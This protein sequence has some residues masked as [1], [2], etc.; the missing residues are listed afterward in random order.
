[1]VL[2]GLTPKGA[3]IAATKTSAE[4][5]GMGR[6]L[7]TIEV[8]KLAD[9]AIVRGNPLEN[10]RHIYNTVYVIKNGRPFDIEKLIPDIISTKISTVEVKKLGELLDDFED[11]DTVPLWRTGAWMDINDRVMGGKS[12]G[13]IEVLQDPD[14]ARGKVL[15]FTGEI[16]KGKMFFAFSMFT[17]V[18]TDDPYKFLDA[19]RYSGVEFWIRG[20]VGGFSVSLGMKGVEYDYHRS[21]V[22]VKESWSLVKIPFSRFK[23]IGFGNK[24]E[25]NP[26]ELTS[27]S[28]SSEGP[29]FG[30]FDLYIDDIK[31]YN[32]GDGK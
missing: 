26:G 4:H 8:G 23:Q 2:A 15:R 21:A 30:R 22:K 9:L 14:K 6:E 18:L 31:F 24:K 29:P 16:K 27:M 5:L 19:S 32:D 12:Y 17:V 1:M 13:K 3:I 25:F 11:G 7:G 20:K 28:F 10:I